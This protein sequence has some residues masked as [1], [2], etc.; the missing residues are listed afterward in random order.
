MNHPCYS[1]HGNIVTYKSPVKC[2][3]TDPIWMLVP[4]L[5]SRMCSLY[6]LV[7]I[8]YLPTSVLFLEICHIY[9]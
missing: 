8:V 1:E 3:V 9:Q 4:R 7:K 2:M 6:K 5:S